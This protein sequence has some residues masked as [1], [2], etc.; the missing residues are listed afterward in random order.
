MYISFPI[1]LKINAG[2]IDYKRDRPRH[3]FVAMCVQNA[4]GVMRTGNGQVDLGLM[5]PKGKRPG[6]HSEQL[7]GSGDECGGSVWGPL[8]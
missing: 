7:Q 8:A 2:F 4:H 5:L 6:R 1:G 3:V